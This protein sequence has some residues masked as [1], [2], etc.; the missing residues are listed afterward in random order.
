[1][2]LALCLLSPEAVAKQIS[3]EEAALVAEQFFNVV[4]PQ[5]AT[6]LS[7]KSLLYRQGAQ[8]SVGIEPT[9]ESQ[10]PCFYLF[11]TD[12]VGF[13]IVSGDDELKQIVGYSL[14]SHF[15]SENIPVQLE[16]LLAQYK[17]GVESFRK[18]C[19]GVAHSAGGVAVQPLI[20]T[21]WN[22][23]E[24]YNM[25]CVHPNSFTR[26][27][28]GCVATAMAQVMKYHNYPPKGNGENGKT[29][30]G[31]IDLSTSA[32]D[33]LN[34][35]DVYNPGD[36]SEQEASAVALLMRDAGVA[37]SMM[38]GT[39]ESDAYS[40]DIAPAMFRHFNYSKDIKFLKR[41][42]YDSQEWIDIIRENL[43]RGEPVIYGARGNGGHE[44]VCD[45]IDMDDY[46]HINWG[47]G[48]ACDGYY[49][50]NAFKPSDVGIGGGDGEYYTGHD[51]VVNIRPGD[52]DADNSDYQAPMMVYGLGLSSSVQLDASGRLIVDADA[53]PLKSN[54]RFYIFNNTGHYVYPWWKIIAVLLDENKQVIDDSFA[55]K[56]FRYGL[57]ARYYIEDDEW[58][59]DFNG[60]S[61]GDYYISLRY[62][63][64]DED[65]EFDFASDPYL[66]VTVKD[67]SL[68]F[69]TCVDNEE[70]L[71]I[72]GVKQTS[73]IYENMDAGTVDVSVINRG[74]HEILNKTVKIHCALDGDAGDNLDLTSLTEV[75]SVVINSI[76]PGAE[77]SFGGDIECGKN[78]L[79][80]GR[81]RLY[82][83]YDGKLLEC[84]EACYVE[85][86]PVPIDSPFVLG[87]QLTNYRESYDNGGSGWMIVNVDYEVVDGWESWFDQPHDFGV[88]AALESQPEDKFLLF[89]DENKY[90]TAGSGRQTVEIF[91]D[92]DLL[93]KKPGEYKFW[94]TYRSSGN[95]EWE[96][97]DDVNNRGYFSVVEEE[98]I[99]PTVIMS[100]PM[101]INGGND[102]ALGADFDATV[103]IW[104]PNG[105]TV[106]RSE[107]FVTASLVSWSRAA[108]CKSCEFDK[109]D[110]APGEETE[111]RMSLRMLDNE[112]Y[113][114]QSFYVLL[115]V[116]YDES[117]YTLPR[118]GEYIESISFK[119]SDL[120][121]SEN[122]SLDNDYS[123]VLSGN[124]L[125]LDGI[126][127]GDVVE[128]WST[129]GTM[130]RREQSEGNRVSISMT[131]L[132]KDVYVVS[133]RSASKAYPSKKMVL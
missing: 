53:D 26:Y 81:Y 37:V 127:K 40:C 131:G 118:P 92:A 79:Q 20:T 44:F 70:V 120:S 12:D 106:L 29:W 11:T 48:G 78:G 16:N 2:L 36:Y 45:G 13:V 111:V 115:M 116:S 126:D 68:Y 21:K 4:A 58:L 89:I 76:Y 124:H 117:L 60:V 99:E 30:L 98:I 14:T 51:I 66:A 19:A 97:I 133:V 63:M 86:S 82:F 3:K 9:D 57:E 31:T 24:P 88:W 125:V 59:I 10:N 65:R 22:Q 132:S 84:N 5:K 102:V 38:Y 1:M 32:Y 128:V 94:L 72:A 103:K 122:I 43:L 27:Y 61:D 108:V 109:T 56:S 8:N 87:G 96:E 39:D 114:G 46:L 28:T 75:G 73:A 83:T 112:E 64:S 47:W 100:E 50:I 95:E 85:V 54:I 113:V 42:F 6:R 74:K 101:V 62:S 71:K 91:G 130:L 90:M 17:S 105:I 25:L 69:P 35:R 23:N 107:A 93:W 52:P 80:P 129:T 49:D 15:D 7:N 119:V 34:M 110:L 77:R 33:W 121:R 55:S 18:G 104:T 123:C 41:E 67:G